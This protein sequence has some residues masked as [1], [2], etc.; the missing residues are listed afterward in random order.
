MKPFNMLC[1]AICVGFG[2]FATACSSSDLIEPDRSA[3]AKLTISLSQNN[4]S[5]E[6]VVLG[7]TIS[8]E[9]SVFDVGGNRV[10]RG[11][12]SWSLKLANGQPAGDSIGSVSVTGP[13]TARILVR[14]EGYFRINASITRGDGAMVSQ[15][16]LILWLPKAKLLASSRSHSMTA[17]CTGCGSGE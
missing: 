13:R 17:T 3:I 11:S 12:V 16:A 14:T 6:Y 8:V 4:P 2:V 15:T 1:T 9:A 10:D 7:D 5:F